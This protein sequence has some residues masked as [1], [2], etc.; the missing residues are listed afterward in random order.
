M[1]AGAVW[2]G[3][4]LIAYP[5]RFRGSFLFFFLVAGLLCLRFWLWE[6]VFLETETKGFQTYEATVIQMR[7][8]LEERQIGIVDIRGERIYLTYPQSEPRL[9]PGDKLLVGGELLEPSAKRV[10]HAFDF[11]NFLAGLNVSRTL[12]AQELEVVGR[13]FSIW[14]YQRLANDWIES[15]LPPLT[16]SYVQALFLGNRDGLEED[17]QS[18]FSDLGLLHLFAISGMH[19]NL[20]SGLLAYGFK[21][22]G[23]LEEIAQFGLLLFLA[24]FAVLAGGSPSIVRAASMSGLG[25]L[26]RQF[27]WRFSSLDL[28]SLVLL[29]NLALAPYQLRQTGFIYSY[30]ITFVL[31]MSRNILSTA[32]GWK[33]FLFFPFLAQLGALPLTLFMNYEINLWSYGANLLLGPV[34]TSVLIPVLLLATFV[35]P[36]SYVTEMVLLLFQSIGLW[37]A[38]TFFATWTTGAF[39]LSLLLWLM[40]IFLAACYGY[41][42]FRRRSIW[43]GAVLAMVFVLEGNRLMGGSQV[44]F[45]DVG[46]GDSII[47]QSPWQACTVVVDTGGQFFVGGRKRPIFHQTLEPFLLGEG[48]RSIDYLI[49]THGD[50]DH[51]GEAREL[52]DRFNVGHVIVDSRDHE[53]YFEVV[54]DHAK[55]LG[56]PIL[57]A[58]TFDELR[59]GNQHY[60]FLQPNRQA[61]DENDAS[62]VKLLEMDGTSVLLTGD[63]GFEV[64]PYVLRNLK[65]RPVDIY[66]SAHHGSRFS[67]SL[68]FM[69]AVDPQVAVVHAGVNNRFGHPTEAWLEVVKQ[70]GIRQFDTPSYGTVQVRISKNGFNI[71]TLIERGD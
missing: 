55:E 11:S 47:I 39:S 44:T 3:L 48:V 65:G 53:G 50:F 15:R 13:S 22:I 10:P 69:E 46:Q 66:K 52:L 27:K 25:I 71:D 62:L 41:E 29:A 2:T 12:Y 64:E 56:V 54:I 45:L 7:R 19:V 70:L 68:A 14:R 33:L 40:V 32:K 57:I 38:R 35:P 6:P 37:S 58:D 20:L 21:R 43:L 59:C 17:M 60:T 4:F 42:K 28:F 31:V 26:N 61:K 23:I 30:W 49:L 34:V 16:A 5:F 9:V 8:Q 67:N 51:I 63:I 36:L 18:A 24:S 1:G